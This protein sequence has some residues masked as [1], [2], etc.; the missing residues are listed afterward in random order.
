MGR[1]DMDIDSKVAT[2]AKLMKL[3]AMAQMNKA[4]GT[5]YHVITILS[6]RII[7]SCLRVTLPSYYWL[8]QYFD[9]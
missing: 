9:P 7:P 2:R 3:E 1:M 4:T 8:S 6:Q 5:L